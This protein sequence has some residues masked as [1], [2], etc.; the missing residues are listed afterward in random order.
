M[1]IKI[2]RRKSIPVDQPIIRGDLISNHREETTVEYEKRLD[3]FVQS[4]DVIDIK[5][6]VNGAYADGDGEVW[7]NLIIMYRDKEKI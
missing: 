3:E 4:V 2:M 5:T 6:E 7:T 1:R